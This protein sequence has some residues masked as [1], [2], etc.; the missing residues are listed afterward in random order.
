MQVRGEYYSGMWKALDDEDFDEADRIAKILL[1]L[2]V[3]SKTLETS[4]KNRDL[5]RAPFKRR[6]RV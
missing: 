4:G 2:G 5:E 3:T 6:S 1:D